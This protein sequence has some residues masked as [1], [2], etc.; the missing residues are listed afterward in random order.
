MMSN[1]LLK[2]YFMIIDIR[3]KLNVLYNTHCAFQHVLDHSYFHLI[4]ASRNHTIHARELAS[5]IM[6]PLAV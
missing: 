5:L 3:P 1:I 6:T 2:I 4:P